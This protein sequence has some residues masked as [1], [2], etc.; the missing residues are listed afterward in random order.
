[1]AINRLRVTG[2]DSLVRDV[3]SN[4]IINTNKTDYQLYMARRTA[5]I[6]DRDMIRNSIREIN[7]LKRELRE[8]KDLLKGVINR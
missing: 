4:A 2:F 6:R 1:M 8:I 3:S 7:N 5:T